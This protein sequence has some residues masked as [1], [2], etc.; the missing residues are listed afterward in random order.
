MKTFEE[1]NESFKSI[2][3]ISKHD[4]ET[5][6]KI[7]KEKYENYKNEYF[8]QWLSKIDADT[9]NKAGVESFRKIWEAIDCCDK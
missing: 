4:T 8:N 5:M 3:Q 1:F 9:I 2:R 6:D 7:I